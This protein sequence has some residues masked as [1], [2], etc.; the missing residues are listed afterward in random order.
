MVSVW[1]NDNLEKQVVIFPDGSISFPLIRRVEVA[2]FCTPEV[3]KH[4]AAKL[5]QYTSDPVKSVVITGINGN[6]A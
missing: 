5:K 3:E 2:G 6:R 1:C 4:V